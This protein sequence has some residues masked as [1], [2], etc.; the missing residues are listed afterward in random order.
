M[1]LVP[2]LIAAW[3]GPRRAFAAQL[4]RGVRE[5]RA[6]MYLMLGCGLVF[7]SQ[8]PVAAR[9][10][11]LD[12]SIPLDARL[13]AAL[14]AW[15]FLAPLILYAIAGLSH[16]VA[17]AIGGAGSFAA[18]RLALF[19]ALFMASPAWLL[20]GLVN[21]MVGSGTAASLVGLAALGAFLWFWGVALVVAERARTIA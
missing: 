2:D 21:G 3:R 6:L 10:A 14:L 1:A 4:A 15:L 16:L 17:R 11:H 5:D 8:W 18:A 20:S 9:E 13:G 12:P 7:V 19:W